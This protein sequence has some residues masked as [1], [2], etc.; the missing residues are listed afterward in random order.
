MP[1]E[2]GLSA[3]PH[4][5]VGE[6][7]DTPPV[8][9]REREREK[10]SQRESREGGGGGGRKRR[11][12]EEEGG[13]GGRRRREE[14]EG[15][16]EGRKRRREEEEEEEEGGEGGRRRRRGGEE[17][18]EVAHH[19]H[20]FILIVHLELESDGSM[21]ECIG[22]PTLLQTQRELRCLKRCGGHRNILLPFTQTQQGS[23]EGIIQQ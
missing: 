21:V 12:E 11:R 1:T 6:S 4:R 16:G 15:G 2:L 9:E 3:C 17:G 23:N 13:G 20:E 18:G 14:E 7:S 5:R 22:T 10:E 8:C 19:K